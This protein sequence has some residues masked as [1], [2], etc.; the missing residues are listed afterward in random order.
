M[1][2][3]SCKL[4]VRNRRHLRIVEKIKKNDKHLKETEEE[5]R[6]EEEE[7]DD[8]NGAQET[9]CQETLGDKKLIPESAFMVPTPEPAPMV[10]STVVTPEPTPEADPI[11]IPKPLRLS[12]RQS[13]IPDSLTVSGTGKSY[14]D[15]M[16]AK[17]V[18]RMV[19][20]TKR[21]GGKRRSDQRMN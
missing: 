2:N 6:M 18:Q 17:F 21:R 4:T 5:A 10:P 3:G 9:P 14:V 16:K 1:V 15:A 7:E 13:K 12:S 11:H 20:K 19:Q 8:N